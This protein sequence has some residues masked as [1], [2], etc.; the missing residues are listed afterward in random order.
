MRE[1]PDWLEVH[2]RRHDADVPA[3]CHWVSDRH[4]NQLRS[5]TGPTR[6]HSVRYYRTSSAS[7]DLRRCRD[8]GNTSGCVGG[9]GGAE[10]PCKPGLAVR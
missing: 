9:V 8:Y 7:A 6:S 10:G 5:H 2:R 3:S 4:L 1:V